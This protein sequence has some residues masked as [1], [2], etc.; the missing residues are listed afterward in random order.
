MTNFLHDPQA[1]VIAAEE[2]NPLDPGRHQQPPEVESAS[3]QTAPLEAKL[4]QARAL[5]TVGSEATAFD[6]GAAD[7]FAELDEAVVE[8]IVGR[9]VRPPLI[10][11]VAIENCLDDVA[12]VYSLPRIMA[13]SAFL[14]IAGAA[15]GTRV[16]ARAGTVWSEP[17]NLWACLVTPAG[18]RRMSVA[19]SLSKPLLTIEEGELARWQEALG[20]LAQEKLIHDGALRTHAALAKRAAAEGRPEPPLPMCSGGQSA[21]VMPRITV[22]ETAPPA[23]VEA[24]VAGRGLFYMA[25]EGGKLLRAARPGEPLGELVLA[26]HDGNAFNVP[27]AMHAD[28]RR[29]EA[30]GLSLLIGTVPGALADLRVERNDQLFA[31]MMWIVPARKPAFAIARDA[32][33]LTVIENILPVLRSWG[34]T[35][36]ELVLDMQAVEVLEQAVRRWEEEAAR[37]GGGPASAWMERAGTQAMRVALVI[38]MLRAATA[39]VPRQPRV[40]SSGALAAAIR[41]VDLVL[42]P[43]MMEALTASGATVPAGLAERVMR[44]V[45]ENKLAAVNRRDL[46]RGHR[47]LFPDGSALRQAFDSLVMAGV[48][49]PVGHLGAK[50][51]P[52][53]S[54]EVNPRLRAAVEK[55]RSPAG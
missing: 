53:V 33:D 3:S 4:R 8:G 10:F 6:D 43:G 31:R 54:Y 47:G 38:E 36:H 26:G 28:I 52:S 1:A 2:G 44:Y 27:S 55:R 39:V 14:V 34:E 25:E 46:S 20:K 12:R 16:R 18:W 32:A 50:G 22:H 24:G 21:P 9:P 30:F 7:G 41:F 23:I 15:I 19:T 45:V 13:T 49:R 48:L 17:P 51:R 29:I 42:V 5:V 11:P 37:L 35:E 40:I